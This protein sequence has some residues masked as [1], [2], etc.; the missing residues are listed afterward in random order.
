M[1]MTGEVRRSKVLYWVRSRTVLFLLLL[2][3]LEKE[4]ELKVRVGS[5]V[6]SPALIKGQSEM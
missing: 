5:A 1:K 3:I 2:W 6:S 4:T